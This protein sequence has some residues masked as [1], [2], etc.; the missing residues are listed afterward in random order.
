VTEPHPIFE[1]LV[2][3][4]LRLRNRIIKTA[5]YEGMVVRGLPSR[6]LL[7]HHVEL[8][9]GGVAMTTV[10]YCAVSPE[11]RT[12]A[13][14]MVMGEA[15]VRPLRVITDAVHAEG[16][17]AM[18][19]LGHCGGFSK[20]EELG[21]RG[22]L[23]PSTGFN[24]YGALKGMPLTRGMNTDDLERTKGDFVR[25][26]RAAFGAGFDAIEVHLGHGYL[27]SQFLSPHRNKR[28]D[29]WGGSLDSRMRFP[30][31][32]V[33]AIRAAVGPERAVFVKMNLDDGVADGLHVDDA[34]QVARALESEGTTALVLSGGLVSHSALYLLRGE[35]PLA[36]MVEVEANLLQKLAIA[37][38]G[39]FLVKKVPFEPMFF[40]PM[41]RRV[42]QSVKLPL[43]Y[44]G[45]ATSLEDLR[46]AREE[47]FEL[48]AMGRALIREPDLA[49]RY[50]KGEAT[51]S[52]CVPCNACITEMDRPG[53]VACAKEPWQLE[54]RADEVRRR[55]HLAVCE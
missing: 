5:T 10:A 9:K 19:Q 55:M 46:R 8:A 17:L 11:G 20:N 53:G 14:Q 13:E 52:R 40:L 42:R 27:L 4:S 7:R 30:L 51:T 32:V 28:T 12:F 35:R 2:L 50:A 38:F 39:P 26:S 24:A 54:R 15:T 25:A 1:P 37:A 31:E 3:G 44:V 29:G 48:V 41:A 36:A 23:G 6:A 43:V 16:A 34:V 45:G 33:R 22:P 18:L 21:L 47:G 49:V